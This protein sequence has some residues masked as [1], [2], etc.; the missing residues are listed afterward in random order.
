MNNL[1]KN[2]SLLLL[3]LLL[4]IDCSQKIDGPLS[5]IYN[6]AKG[7]I[8]EV[9]KLNN[10]LIK[11]QSEKRYAD[12]KKIFD[13]MNFKRVQTQDR[14]NKIISEQNGITIPFDQ[15]DNSS[16][17]EIKQIKAIGVIWN[18]NLDPNLVF[19]ATVL[20][21]D[22]LR[23]SFFGRWDF[24]DFDNKIIDNPAFYSPTKL[25]GTPPGEIVE[26]KSNTTFSKIVDLQ[27]F[28][29]K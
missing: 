28:I 17:F 14:L 26:L 24:I 5:K 18:S 3:T 9:V 12:I 6:A 22:S 15:Q 1:I 8:T 21:K 20:L 27:K 2:F 23:D 19:S 25:I 11:A 29:I 7:D 4:I 10:E 16:V 13:E